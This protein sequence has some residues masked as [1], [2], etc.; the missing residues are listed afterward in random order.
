MLEL[1]RQTRAGSLSDS[2]FGQRFS[3]TGPYAE[4]LARRFGRAARQ[5]GLDQRP[6]LDCA[7]FVPPRVVA[8]GFAEAQ[9]SLF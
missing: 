3:G 8:S 5:W 9:L 7:Q 4:L 1:I 6:E 2:R